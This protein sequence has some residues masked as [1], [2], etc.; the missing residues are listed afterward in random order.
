MLFENMRR[1]W[2][3]ALITILVLCTV[4][5]VGATAAQAAHVQPVHVHPCQDASNCFGGYRAVLTPAS[6]WSATIRPGQFAVTSGF[7]ASWIGGQTFPGTNMAGGGNFI[8]VGVIDGRFYATPKMGCSGNTGGKT[9]VFWYSI[10]HDGT[11][12]ACGIGSVVKPG[13]A[14]NFRL[15][16]CGGTDWC[17]FVNGRMVH[18]FPHVDS[19]LNT[20]KLTTEVSGSARG[21]TAFSDWKH[22]GQRVQRAQLMRQGGGYAVGALGAAWKV[23]CS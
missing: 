17:V 4:A 23:R 16:N 11:P 19:T 21:V 7:L 12:L 15:A 5:M 13:Q 14:V 22:D 10:R 1:H 6:T 9:R 18:H 8:Q 3:F 2:L 20:S